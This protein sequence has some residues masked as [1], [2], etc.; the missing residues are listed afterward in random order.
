MVPEALAASISLMV[1]RLSTSWAALAIWRG[2]EG[3]KPIAMTREVAEERVEASDSTE[4]F[5]TVYTIAFEQ[6]ETKLNVSSW[7][8]CI[9]VRGIE[10]ILL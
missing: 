9:N 8:Y 1:P 5:A 3:T 4:S 2:L 6:I 7:Y 10:S